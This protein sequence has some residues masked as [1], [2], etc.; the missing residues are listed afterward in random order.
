MLFIDIETSSPDPEN[1]DWSLDPRRCKIDLIGIASV[2]AF[3]GQDPNHV[4]IG[5]TNSIQP[6]HMQGQSLCGHHFKFDLKTLLCKGYTIKLE[7]YAHDTQIMAAALMTKV[8]DDYIKRYEEKR[9]ELNAALPKG[10]GYREAKKHSLKVLAPFFL[11]VSPFWENPETTNDPEYLKKDVLYTKGLYDHFIPM[12][13]KE[14]VWE[15]YNEKLMPWS[16]MC[17]QAEIDG[18]HI[19]LEAMAEMQAKAE[20][21]VFTSLA[22]LRAAWAKVEEEW[23]AKCKEEIGS[24]YREMTNKAIERIKGKTEEE[25]SLK[26]PGVVSRY[27]EL[28]KK[29]IAKIEPFNYGSP[30][31][32]LWAFKEVL[33][34]PAVNME[35]DETTG[36]EVLELL[37]VDKPDVKALLEYREA[38]KLVHSY[39]PSYR[40]LMVDGRINCSFNMFPRT[41]RLSCSEPNLQQVPPSLKKIFKPAEGNSFVSQD[42]SAIEPVLIAYYTED[43]NLCRILINGEDFHGWAAVLFQLVK[44]AVHEVKAK[45]PTVRYAAK[46]GDLSTFY[47]SGKKRLFTTLTLN[48]IK[49]LSNGSPLTEQ[50]CQKMVYAFRDYFHEAWEF[51]Q[52]LDA[53]LIG[54]N[55][56]ENLFGRRFR[57][58]DPADV[59]MKGFNTLIQGSASDL[60]LQGTIDCIFE[61][62]AKGI[63]VRLRLLV[64]DNTVLECRDK[65]AEYVNS[66]LCYHLTKFKL[67]TKHGLIPLKVEGGYG[68]TWKA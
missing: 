28:R 9:R 21:G 5:T 8:P 38:Y 60:L 19:N 37:A 20:A 50:E 29:A 27:E 3:Q 34:Y 52:M 31:Q 64:H 48:G 51:K 53:E 14:G 11:G 2:P 7:Q 67:K 61:M 4:M 10:K 17:L 57:I 59:Y 55:Y 41:G 24:H 66:R 32:I 18:I 43:E 58:E 40:A 1:P 22:K 49:K 30:S 35:G 16:R 6:A 45:E 47:G 23:Q 62:M 56:A 54:G 44:C 15:F 12:M 36:A 42:L 39:F 13:K 33:K 26:R 25:K 68:K 65:D 63:W 46:Q